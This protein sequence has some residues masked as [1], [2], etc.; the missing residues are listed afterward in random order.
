[1][2]TGTSSG[3]VALYD[4]RRASPLAL[5]DHGYGLPMVDIKFHSDKYVIS[6]DPKIIKVC[7]SDRIA[8]LQFSCGPTAIIAIMYAINPLA[9]SRGAGM[10][11]AIDRL[12]I[13]EPHLDPADGRH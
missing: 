7:G 8:G 13:D 1:M 12:C 3:H 6:A 10:G 9:S 4:I 5:K 11:R 2:C